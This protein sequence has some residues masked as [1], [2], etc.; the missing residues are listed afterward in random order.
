MKTITLKIEYEIGDKIDLGD[1]IGTFIGYEYIK[2]RSMRYIIMVLK[3]N[4]SEWVYL[5]PFE[6]KA[7][8]K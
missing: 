7:L 1:T 2:G 5:Y 3:N 6:L 8:S 4:Q